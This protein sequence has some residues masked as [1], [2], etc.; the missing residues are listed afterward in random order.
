MSVLTLDEGELRNVADAAA[1]EVRA[2][3]QVAHKPVVVD[4]VRDRDRLG[5]LGLDLSK[6]EVGQRKLDAHF[7]APAIAGPP[8]TAERAPS[9]LDRLELTALIVVHDGVGQMH[10]DPQGEE[11]Q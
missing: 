6:S 9:M 4:L 8:T 7:L 5:T 2:P 1:E 10:A 3:G 11:D